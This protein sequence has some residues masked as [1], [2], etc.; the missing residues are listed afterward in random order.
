MEYCPPSFDLIDPILF[1]IGPFDLFGLEL[2]F[3]LRWY[4][5]AYIAG[6]MLGWRYM[7]A[8]SRRPAMWNPIG[9]KKPKA[10]FTEPQVDDLLIWATLGVIGGGRLGFVLFYM[11]DM[12]WTRPQDIILGITDGGMSFHGGLIGVSL[13]LWWFARGQKLDLMRIADAAAVVTPIGLFF[14]RLANFINGELWGR[15]TDVPWAMRFTGDRLCELR[16]PSQLYEAALEGLL[17]F[18]IINVATWKFRSLEKPGFNAGLFL[19]FYGL[20]RTSLE[21]V[22]EPDLYMPEAL[23][24]YITMGMLLSI[25]MIIAGA[26]LIHRALKATTPAKS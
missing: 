26:W 11:P 5:L 22:R 25:P 13:A 24:G 3:D 23:R 10:P 18:T 4:A 16:H 15:P 1:T 20:F 21:Q 12:I 9:T 6:L 19:L 2:R 7:V 14:G 8:L 17:L